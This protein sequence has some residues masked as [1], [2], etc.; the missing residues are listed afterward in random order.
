MNRKREGTRK[1]GTDRPGLLV[2]LDF[3]EPSRRALDQA[4]SLA[5][6]RDASL[7]ILHVIDGEGLKEAA[8]LAEIPEQ[9][10]REKL[11]RERR[12]R[13]EGVV[14]EARDGSSDV[15]CQILI[16]WGRPFQ[17]ILKRSAEYAV[18]LIVLGTAGRS[19]DLERALFGSTAEKVLRGA[20]CPVLC[21]PSDF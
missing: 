4:L 15:P 12:K 9:H 14:A 16:A 13:L 18:N 17:E 5:R 3:S 6:E 7:L 21:V 19:A 2:G 10:L 20:S 1:D 8:H 11:E